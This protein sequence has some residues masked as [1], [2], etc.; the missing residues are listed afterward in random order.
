MFIKTKV[1]KLL[2][3]GKFSA[4]LH[5]A[6]LIRVDESVKYPKKYMKFNYIK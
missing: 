4:V 3:K 5:F 1:E 2:K 6:G